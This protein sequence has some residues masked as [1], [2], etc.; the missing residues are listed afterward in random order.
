MR[1][2]VFTGIV[3]S[4]LM[5]AG[6]GSTTDIYNDPAVKDPMNPNRHMRPSE[7][8]KAQENRLN[9]FNFNSD[10]SKQA[11]QKV[12]A[13]LWRATLGVLREFPL[14]KIDPEGQFVMTEWYSPQAGE[15][16]KIYVQLTQ[17]ELTSQSVEVKVY[18]RLTRNGK[19]EE[20]LGHP[21]LETKIRDEILNRAREIR[22][23]E[24]KS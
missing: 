19:T 22:V 18:K 23:Q 16:F 9:L 10:S 14:D 6:C 15:Q 7:A 24:R 12:N 17:H 2:T 20:T 8:D 4:A 1:Q 3:L 13:Y 5:L 11:E 21:A